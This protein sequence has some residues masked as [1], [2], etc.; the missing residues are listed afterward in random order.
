MATSVLFDKV[1]PTLS[2]FSSNFWANQLLILK[3]FASS[4]AEISFEWFNGGV[5][6]ARIEIVLFNCPEWGV[7][8][9]RIQFII[10]GEPVEFSSITTADITSCDSLVSLCLPLIPVIQFSQARLQFALFPSTQYVSIAEVRL[11][12]DGDCPISTTDHGKL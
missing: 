5:D 7:A 2:N 4:H 1:I 8:A 6:L 10:P 9:Q 11:F 12:S 3:P